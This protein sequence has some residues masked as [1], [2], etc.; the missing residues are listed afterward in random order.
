[1][2]VILA[3][4]INELALS[5]PFSATDVWLT[6]HASMAFALQLYLWCRRV[7]STTRF[8]TT[9]YMA[10]TWT[11]ASETSFRSMFLHISAHLA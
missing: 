9:S 10:I 3:S 7:R 8:Y 4:T 2:D 1:M 5:E 11:S 6:V